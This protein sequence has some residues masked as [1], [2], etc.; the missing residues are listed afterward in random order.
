MPNN[1]MV[2]TFSRMQCTSTFV[3]GMYYIKLIHT[4]YYNNVQCTYASYHYITHRSTMYMYVFTYVCAAHIK[5]PTLRFDSG[6]GTTDKKCVR[7]TLG[8][9]IDANVVSTLVGITLHT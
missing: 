6:L 5:N 1:L 9:L 8:P 3:H 2:M 4:M 7:V